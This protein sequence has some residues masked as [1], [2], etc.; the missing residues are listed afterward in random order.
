M[1]H[2][3]ATGG[4]LLEQHATMEDLTP[5]LELTLMWWKRWNCMYIQVIFTA[6]TFTVILYRINCHIY[7][8]FKQQ[9]FLLRRKPL[10]WLVAM[11]PHH[12]RWRCCMQMA[13]A[14]AAS[15]IWPATGSATVC[16]GEK[17]A[18]VTARTHRALSSEMDPGPSPTHCR[19]S[20]RVIQRGLHLQ[21]SFC[22]EEWETRVLQNFFLITALSQPCI[23]H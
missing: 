16:Q 8:D 19:G 17:F 4:L 23:S 7:Y 13:Q 15:R 20:G 9:R 14:G 3:E 11:A 21:A 1:L 2:L 12:R 5:F 6:K 10:S 18:G 22:S